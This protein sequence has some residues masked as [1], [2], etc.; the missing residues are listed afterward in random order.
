MAL[1]CQYSMPGTIWNVL[2]LPHPWPPPDPWQ[3]P[4]QKKDGETIDVFFDIS[5]RINARV[6]RTGG[7][8]KLLSQP[9]LFD[10][11]KAITFMLLWSDD[12]LRAMINGIELVADSGARNDAA[13]ARDYEQCGT[14]CACSFAIFASLSIPSSVDGIEW[15]FL[16]TLFD[17]DAKATRN[18]TYD[19]I[20]ASGLLRLLLLDSNCLVHQANR[21]LNLPRFGG[22]PTTR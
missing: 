11:N 5:G 7:E 15:F 4:T 1:A 16:E 17:I 21:K 3:L 14:R 12:E 2:T 13:Q 8:L 10:G 18:T 22:Q 19:L 9:V 6:A 20:K